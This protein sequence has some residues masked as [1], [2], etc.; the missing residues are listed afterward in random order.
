MRRDDAGTCAVV[1]VVP[2]DVEDGVLDVGGRLVHLGGLGLLA[3]QGVGLCA[4]RRGLAERVDV[5]AWTA[6]QRGDG[7]GRDPEKNITLATCNAT[8]P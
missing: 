6:S 5:V 3:D 2:Q 4:R 7:G 8:P 1:L